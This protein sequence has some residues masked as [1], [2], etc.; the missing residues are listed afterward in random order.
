MLA[1]ES[2]PPASPAELT[3][4]FVMVVAA[5]LLV[6]LV[7]WI[8]E[9][10]D[11]KDSSARAA[12]RNSGLRFIDDDFDDPR[13]TPSTR[14]RNTPTSDRHSWLTSEDI[15]TGILEVDF[16]ECWLTEDELRQE[17][18]QLAFQADP[19]KFHSILSGLVR[20]GTL[21]RAKPRNQPAIYRR[22][23]PQSEPL[24]V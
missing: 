11:K 20:D 16:R 18:G 1:L 4:T 8:I 17:L 3:I 5:I 24:S 6:G 7:T 19:K 15:R 2:P 14:R 12:P 9:G 13:E 22:I 23:A 21:R 10:S